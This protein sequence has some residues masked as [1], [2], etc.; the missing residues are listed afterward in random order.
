MNRVEKIIL[1]L[2]HGRFIFQKHVCLQK[3][4]QLNIYLDK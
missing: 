1:P 2:I 4:L 3:K